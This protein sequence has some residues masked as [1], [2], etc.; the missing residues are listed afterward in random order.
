MKCDYCN[1]EFY[2]RHDRIT[3]KNFCSR[4]CLGAYLSENPSY[5]DLS[6]CSKHRTKLNK[7]LNKDRMTPEVK[8]KIRN[9]RI[10]SGEGKTYSKLYGVHEHRVIAESMLGRPLRKGEVVHHIDFNK[11]NNDT[12]NLMVFKNQK[13]HLEWH[14]V[15][16]SRF[17]GGDAHEVQTT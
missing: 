2:K 7:E 15:N 4:K 12:K 13:E 3:P 11:R 17:R 9:S 1:K 8:K 5:R 14:R 16:D 6:K 10:N